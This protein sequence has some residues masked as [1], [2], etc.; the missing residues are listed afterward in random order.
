MAGLKDNVLNADMYYVHD[1]HVPADVRVFPVAAR[2]IRRWDEST[3]VYDVII[4]D[5][6]LRHYAFAGRWFAINCTFDLTGR[7]VTECTEADF[8]WCFNC[9]ICTPLFSID[10]NLY[11]VDLCLDLLVA[12][13]GRYT[14]KDQDEFAHASS[15]GWFTEEEQR[16][17]TTGVEELVDIIRGVGLSLFLDN[18]CSFDSVRDSH[19]ALPMERKRFEDVPILLP[20]VRVGYFGKRIVNPISP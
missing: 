7:F 6:V 12:P 9:D 3:F 18:I 10:R 4:G 17:A 16:N 14:V 8:A 5:I 15:V 19:P 13:D 2:C 1:L 11:S 20:E